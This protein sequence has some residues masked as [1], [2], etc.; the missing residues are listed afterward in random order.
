MLECSPRRSRRAL[1]VLW[2][3]SGSRDFPV[4]SHRGRV[5]VESR[6]R[7]RE[8]EVRGRSRPGAACGSSPR[9]HLDRPRCPSCICGELSARP[10]PLPLS[11]CQRRPAEVWVARLG[12][13]RANA[14]PA[15]P[16][17]MGR[18]AGSGRSR[19]FPIRPSR[20]VQPSP[21]HK[22]QRRRGGRAPCAKRSVAVI[23]RERVMC[24]A[25]NRERKRRLPL[26]GPAVVECLRK[27]MEPACAVRREKRKQSS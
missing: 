13:S 22:N 18:S 10:S 17:L 27:M 20:F 15:G 14:A 3:N 16:G 9:V 19:P 2:E 5:A 8:V 7:V 12:P 1:V 26:N 6:R 11:H 24:G 25:E 21:P 23:D 4:R